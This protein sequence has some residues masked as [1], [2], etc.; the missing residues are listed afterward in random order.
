MKTGKLYF[1]RQTYHLRKKISTNKSKHRGGVTK[2]NNKKKHK[3]LNKYIQM[4]CDDS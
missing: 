3:Y 2:Q 4:I 1:M